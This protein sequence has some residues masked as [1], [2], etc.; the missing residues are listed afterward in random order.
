M[1]LRRF[2]LAAFAV[3][4]LIVDL[5]APARLPAQEVATV[6]VRPRDAEA[7][8]GEQIQFTAVGMDAGDIVVSDRAVAWVTLPFDLA[9]ADENGKVT[10]FEPGVVQVGAVVGGKVGF[11]SVTV[12]P[13]RVALLEI[14]PLSAPLV[15]GGSIA[16]RATPKTA[17]GLTRGDARIE[18]SSSDPA[19]VTVD[20]AGLATGVGP[21]RAIVRAA[22]EGATGELSVEVVAN[23]VRRLSIEPASSTKRTGDV[24]RFTARAQGDG[25][26][27]ANPLVRW[28]VSG[29]GAAI[30]EGGAFVAERPG[31]YVVSGTSGVA[32][33]TASV[34]V[35]PR[36][37]S[38]ALTVVG[39][40]PVRDIQAAEQWIV[41]DHAYLSTAA[42]RLWVFDISDPANPIKTDSIVVDARHVNDVSTTADGRIG[43]LTR[44]GAAS[45]RNGVVFFD[46][47]NPGHPEVVSEYTETVTGGVHSAF[48]DGHYAYL[49][50]D[51]TGSL[52]VIDF[53]D[54]RNPREVARWQVER[55]VG[56]TLDLPENAP[57]SAGRYLHDLQVVDG[58]AYLAY[59]K[60]GLVILDVG[61]GLKGGSPESPQLVSQLRF[62]HHELYGSGWVAGTHAVFRYKNYVFVGDEVLPS[63]FDI[64]GKERIP[65]R[66]MVHVIDVSDIEHPR[67]VAWY[68][69]PEGGSHNMWVEDDVLAMGDYQGGGR[70]LDVSGE[71]RGDLYRQGREIARLWTGDPEGFRPN[72]PLTWGAQHHNGLIFFNDLNSGLW[73]TRLGDAIETGSAT[74][75]PF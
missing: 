52:R 24:V 41:G 43:I 63:V 31:T 34:V 53:S 30:D 22:S 68:E 60:D 50:D 13:G 16:L 49:T 69:V 55:Q 38:R 47:S 46:A 40:A 62:N 67:R 9:A 26:A 73:I 51:A 6:E 44:E 21:G 61:A 75:P 42:D 70:V 5:G 66:G 32:V 8:P 17:S 74:A 54:V 33:A 7:E 59:W 39:R 65:T 15:P 56:R 20:G 72:M 36:D 45:R 27:V 14:A 2:L 25:G 28:S 64:Y 3:S 19:V 23:P 58:I 71:L 48:L 37:V 11:T 57:F 1:T 29:E 18:W 10:F 12:R 35:A 4:G